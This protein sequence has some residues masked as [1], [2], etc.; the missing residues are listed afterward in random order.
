[1]ARYA[2][3]TLT[4][5]G[6]WLF[7]EEAAEKFDAVLSNVERQLQSSYEEKLQ[8][9]IQNRLKGVSESLRLKSEKYSDNK[10]IMKDIAEEIKAVESGHK[11]ENLKKELL[12]DFPIPLWDVEVRCSDGVLISGSRMLELYRIKEGKQQTALYLR[13]KINIPFARF[14]EIQLNIERESGIV[15]KIDPEVFNEYGKILDDIDFELS[16]IAPNKYF[17]LWSKH[18]FSAL[19]LLSLMAF[20][21][22]IYF[23]PKFI[24][25]K[26]LYKQEIVTLLDKPS[27]SENDARLLR[28]LAAYV[29]DY[30]AQETPASV[31]PKQ[32]IVLVVLAVLLFFAP[33]SNIIGIG[34]GRE[35][36]SR[37]RA[38]F[39]VLYFLVPV[40]L[41]SGWL[42]PKFFDF[43]FH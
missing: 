19:V 1:M 14:R 30:G 18:R 3:P 42:L 32:F 37:W 9:L 2:Q 10:Y 16:K 33:P 31:N 5:P 20:V 40:S 29:T 26:Y 34:K 13:A 8:K 35:S 21:G 12:R 24:S 27:S 6:P 22:V 43:L 23:S 38:W 15:C 41:M 11:E 17:V 4:W 28:P 7:D 36:I 39:K 25:K